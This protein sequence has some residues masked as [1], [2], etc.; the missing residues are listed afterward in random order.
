G[1]AESGTYVGGGVPVAGEPACESACGGGSSG[2]TGGRGVSH[3]GVALP[4]A[5][6]FEVEF[7]GVVDAVVGGERV[8]VVE[9]GAVGAH[10][11]VAEPSDGPELAQVVVDGARELHASMVTHPRALVRV[12]RR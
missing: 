5:Q 8:E 11:R 2:E 9:V 1:G 7:G 4:R 6:Q 3:G 10:G 12:I